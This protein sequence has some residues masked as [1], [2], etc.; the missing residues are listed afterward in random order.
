MDYSD[1]GHGSI[2]FSDV[3]HFETNRHSWVRG[4]IEM[5]FVVD[6]ALEDVN[7][8]GL[9]CV[10]FDCVMLCYSDR[11]HQAR[12]IGP[13][14]GVLNLTMASWPSSKIGILGIVSGR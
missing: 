2:D 8:L 10:V 14:R 13:R 1:H 12:L 11:G 5:A 7:D 4:R 6:S 3:V 9:S